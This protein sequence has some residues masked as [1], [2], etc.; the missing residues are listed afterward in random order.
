MATRDGMT[1]GNESFASALHE[2]PYL[3]VVILIA[4]VAG[5]LALVIAVIFFCKYCVKG[6][7]GLNRTPAFFNRLPAEVQAERARRR[8]QIL[9]AAVQN[10]TEQ[11]A[12]LTLPVDGSPERLLREDGAANVDRDVSEKLGEEE[13]KGR[14]TPPT[15][16][17]GEITEC[18]SEVLEGLDT[19]RTPRS[20]HTTR[21]REVSF[22]VTER[23][24]RYCDL[25]GDV[26]DNAQVVI[27]RHGDMSPLHPPSVEDFD[28]PNRIRGKSPRTL[29]N[30]G[31]VVQS[32]PTRSGDSMTVLVQVH[33]HPVN[34]GTGKRDPKNPDFKSSKGEINQVRLHDERQ[35]S[36]IR[37]S[38]GKRER[39][40]SLDD[41]VSIKGDRSPGRSR[42][43]ETADSDKRPIDRENKEERRERPETNGDPVPIKKDQMARASEYRDLWQLRS[44]LEMQHSSDDSGSSEYDTVIGGSGEDDERMLPPMLRSP[45]LEEESS[46][47][48]K[49]EGKSGIDDSFEQPV[50]SISAE[51]SDVSERD[52]DSGGSG[53]D[54]ARNL[55][56]MHG[57]SGYASIEQKTETEWKRR[58]MFA[59]S[60]HESTS[61]E[62][63]QTFT[64]SS[65]SSS[66]TVD[67]PLVSA[68]VGRASEESRPMTRR[69]D[70]R[71]ASTKRREFVAGREEAIFGS[72]S[73]PEEETETSGTE[74]TMTTG[75][76]SDQALSDRRGA[77]RER[78]VRRTSPLAR[79]RED[80]LSCYPKGRD[81]SIDEKTDALFK[82]FLKQDVL[83][84]TNT[85]RS[86]PYRSHRL[87]LH[88][89]QH[90]DSMLEYPTKIVTSQGGNEPRSVSFESRAA[91]ESS[92]KERLT[93][94]L[95]GT[96][97][98]KSLISQDSI[99]EEYL[100]QERKK[101]YSADCS[102]DSRS[103]REPS[104]EPSPT[105]DPKCHPAPPYK[106]S[107]DRHE[108]AAILDVPPR[109]E[110]V[111][112]RRSAFRL[113]R[114][115]PQVRR[116][117][118]ASFHDCAVTAFSADLSEM[119]DERERT[120]RESIPSRHS[121]DLRDLHDRQTMEP[122][123]IL[124]GGYET[125]DE[126]HTP[127]RED[128]L[129]ARGQ[130]PHPIS[131]SRRTPSD[132][133][134][135]S[136][137]SEERSRSPRSRRHQR[138][139]D[140][141][142]N[143]GDSSGRGVSPG[144][145]GNAAHYRSAKSP[146]RP[147]RSM[148]SLSMDRDDRVYRDSAEGRRDFLQVPGNRGTGRSASSSPRHRLRKH[149]TFGGVSR[150]FSEECLSRSD[151]PIRDHPEYQ[152]TFHQGRYVRPI[153]FEKLE[154]P[155]KKPHSKQA[156][157][158]IRFETTRAGSETALL[159]CRE[160]RSR[161]EARR[162]PVRAHSD[163]DVLSD[164]RRN[165]EQKARSPDK[166]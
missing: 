5:G 160:E 1:R 62:S 11:T 158:I 119:D 166:F 51:D 14:W 112:N 95:P 9:E 107:Y 139:N 10:R 118:A 2:N 94:L 39:D 145:S 110:D 21:S 99:E 121:L 23:E 128:R 13:G 24:A 8:R 152:Q 93:T 72:F 122:P 58:Q 52:R 71:T 144:R 70:R 134:L 83:F 114:R 4:G 149:D 64:M 73:F 153:D 56:K 54:A 157:K 101:T 150:P 61:F 125:P 38:G 59:A 146:T 22:S 154:K 104:R 80:G 69:G 105:G 155:H 17:L 111:K 103:S 79:S 161:R 108:K 63:A 19:P 96:G 35:R 40:R 131:P 141:S 117:G 47:Q 102:P 66:P 77:L 36:P 82:E 113:V 43:K 44:T 53:K 16:T 126:Q 123:T 163:Q 78:K 67:K 30:P 28:R 12:F 165:G 85:R 86:R 138:F 27:R 120:R 159:D 91:T 32:E 106:H 74:S 88:N 84:D 164:W 37:D 33:N 148:E 87:Q 162:S 31:E 127:D 100:R 25:N 55:R 65:D 48:E 136:P 46:G 97:R 68:V 75:K 90:S 76:D 26:A 151:E 57:D 124:V 116:A 143:R 156:E 15:C 60:D 7:R 109:L 140:V 89:K 147:R 142:P 6:K 133:Y 135:R 20:N 42:R 129:K 132:E 18:D 29:L 98:S 137:R 92:A 115:S 49:S 81:Y 34:D 45:T 41:K 50:S 3:T 130:D